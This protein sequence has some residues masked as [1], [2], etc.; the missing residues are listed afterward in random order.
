MNW[1]LT[2]GVGYTLSY[3]KVT[4][5]HDSSSSHCSISVYVQTIMVSDNPITEV[6]L[7]FWIILTWP[8]TKW[9]PLRVALV[10][11]ALQLKVKVT[12][13]FAMEQTTS[14]GKQNGRHGRSFTNW[15]SASCCP[16]MKKPFNGISERYAPINIKPHSPLPT[17]HRWG[18]TKLAAQKT[19]ASQEQHI[20]KA[21][22]QI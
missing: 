1:C 17:W 16:S 7:N 14:T 10:T 4:S 15:S 13:D 19:P 21:P 11:K 9:I 22:L 20:C 2:T 12:G 5:P 18:F 3:I 8:M 6:V